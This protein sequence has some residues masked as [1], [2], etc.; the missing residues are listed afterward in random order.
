MK[1]KMLFAGMLFLTSVIVL[2]ACASGRTAPS[3]SNSDWKLVSYGLISNQTTAT[4]GIDTSLKFGADGQVNGNMGCNS[5]GGEYTQKDDQITF[6]ALASTLMACPEPQMSQE[7][8]SF[9]IL[10]GSVNFT[11]DGDTL[12]IVDASGKNE[13]VLIRQ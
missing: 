1:K 4:E 6:G 8:T 7:G 11:I 12:T 10:T 2:A 13:L 5:F 3:L 9:A